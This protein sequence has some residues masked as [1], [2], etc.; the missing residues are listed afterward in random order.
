MGTFILHVQ[1]REWAKVTRFAKRFTT[2]FVLILLS[3]PSFVRF[4]L[5]AAMGVY[6][7]GFF[8]VKKRHTRDTIHAHKQEEVTGCSRGTWGGGGL[9]M[10]VQIGS[11]RRHEPVRSFQFSL[12]FLRSNR[13]GMGEGVIEGLFVSLVLFFSYSFSG[14]KDNGTLPP[15]KVEQAV[16]KRST[17]TIKK[18]LEELFVSYKV[19]KEEKKTREPNRS[20]QTT[21]R[22]M[23][24]EGREEGT[25]S[26]F[27]PVLCS[28]VLFTWLS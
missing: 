12:S 2:D 22:D 16:S 6:W 27:L 18:I 11:C 28:S 13:I 24:L 19:D 8:K 9:S 7:A 1:L 5:I 25:L 23:K 17:V 14:R 4:T 3:L 15:S 26:T 10:T 20:K 21:K